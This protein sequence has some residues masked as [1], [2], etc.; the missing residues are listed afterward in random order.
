MSKDSIPPF[1]VPSDM[2]ALAEQ[3]VEQAK[4]A[5]NTFINAA[6]EAMT[7]FEGQTK[8]AQAGAR[9]VG[10]KAIAYAEHNVA[11]AFDFAQ[12]VVRASSPQEL[13]RLQTEYVQ[14]QMQ[15]LGEQARDL[16]ETAA[17]SVISG[18][19]PKP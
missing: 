3:S 14:A 10:D 6:Q 7:R 4:V 15:A 12:K 8:I 1:G 5:F 11:A 13:L 19:N 9:D 18:V 17:K 2:R 16:G